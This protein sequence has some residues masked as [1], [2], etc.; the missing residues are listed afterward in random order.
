MDVIK[1]VIVHDA[2]GRPKIALDQFRDGLGTL[3]LG[4]SMK[5]YPNLFEEYFVP[6]KAA[7]SGDSVVAILEYDQP[8]SEA[9]QQTKEYL[10]DFLI[11]STTK[12]VLKFLEFVTACP[13][14][15]K[16]GFGKIQIKFASVSSIFAAACFD[17]LTLPRSFPDRDTFT[18][19]LVAAVTTPSKSFSST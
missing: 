5:Q 17:K 12:T 2:I 8:L 6:S 18:S 11:G 7:V 3:G 14:I 16:Y 1:S 13:R 4:D 10:E 9:E 19:S 15:P